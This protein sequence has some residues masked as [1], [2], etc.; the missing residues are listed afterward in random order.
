MNSSEESQAVPQVTIDTTDFYRSGAPNPLPALPLKSEVLGPTSL[1]HTR[2]KPLERSIVLA[3]KDAGI[4][5]FFVELTHRFVR[6][7]SPTAND[8]TILISMKRD[9]QRDNLTVAVNEV[10]NILFRAQISNIRVEAI[11]PRANRRFFVPIVPTTFYTTMWGKLQQEITEILGR[12]NY[13]WY[14]FTVLNRGHEESQ[15]EPVIVIGVRRSASFEWKIDVRSKVLDLL[16]EAKLDMD[17]VFV[18]ETE[19]SQV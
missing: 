3:L 14:S 4:G 18:R 16:E 11:D 17:V 5:S 9:Q 12:T 19:D 10:L 15:S 7:E 6:G 8:V 1:E 13:S 2:Y